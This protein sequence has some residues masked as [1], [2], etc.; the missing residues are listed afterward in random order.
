MTGSFKQTPILGPQRSLY[1]VPGES[2]IDGYA[3]YMVGRMPAPLKIGFRFTHTLEG[4]RI[5]GLHIDDDDVRPIIVHGVPQPAVSVLNT[6]F[7]N[8]L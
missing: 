8:V 5:S 1:Q 6:R 3:G 2:A 4:C 7:T